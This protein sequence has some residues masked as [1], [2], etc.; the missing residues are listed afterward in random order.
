M[1]LLVTLFLQST[2]PT[3]EASGM[4]APYNFSVLLVQCTLRQL[5]LRVSN[6]SPYLTCRS[7]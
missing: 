5:F 4:L 2:D 1:N 3:S 6:S 7:T